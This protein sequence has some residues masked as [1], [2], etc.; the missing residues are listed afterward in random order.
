MKL[1]RRLLLK[2]V[3]TV[4]IKKFYHY[5]DIDKIGH[6]QKK[7]DCNRPSNF[8]GPDHYYCHKTS[9]FDITLSL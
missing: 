1:M 9:L 8:L 6:S 3:W 2:L 5:Q 4:N 7:W